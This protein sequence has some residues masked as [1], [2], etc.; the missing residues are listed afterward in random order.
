MN[1]TFSVPQLIG[2]FSVFYFV[3]LLSLAPV[4]CI[5]LEDH[6]KISPIKQLAIVLPMTAE[7]TGWALSRIHR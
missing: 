6:A 7:S 2:L 5:L 3:F 1:T 4:G